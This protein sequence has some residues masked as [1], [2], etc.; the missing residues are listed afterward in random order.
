ML[1]FLRRLWQAFF[2]A[3]P[4]WAGIAIY[5]KDYHIAFIIL[6][7]ISSICFVVALIGIYL[8]YRDARRKDRE[9][10]AAKVRGEIEEGIRELNERMGH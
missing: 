6:L 1:D 4:V 5:F 7:I 3:S 10:K 2:I 8:D 9:A